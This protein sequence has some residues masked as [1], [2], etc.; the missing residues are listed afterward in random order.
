MNLCLLG[1]WGLR[2]NGLFCSELRGQEAVL[3]R[4]L[5]LL[6]SSHAMRRGGLRRREGIIKIGQI[7]PRR[8]SAQPR[9]RRQFS[10]FR[11]TDPAFE[12][13]LRQHQSPL[14]GNEILRGRDK[15]TETASVI[16][17]ITC[18][19]KMRPRIPPVRGYSRA[20]REISVCVG[21]RGGAGRTRTS[22]QTIIAETRVNQGSPH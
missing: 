9:R 4:S 6:L 13:S 1:V 21:L 2:P 3:R 22:N 17:S 19:D 16:Q 11:R 5:A 12:P 20:S 15:A 7:A 10:A 18:R 14:P 8:H